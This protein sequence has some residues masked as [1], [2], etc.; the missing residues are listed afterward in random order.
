[1]QIKV[2][3]EHFL[4]NW[5]ELHKSFAR[6]DDGVMVQVG[7]RFVT[8]HAHSFEEAM[9]AVVTIRAAIA[10]MKEKG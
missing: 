6:R 3:F 10:K 1:M 2:T 8:I 9:C 4:S 5:S 7:K